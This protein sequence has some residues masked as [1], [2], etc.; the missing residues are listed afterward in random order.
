VRNN[1]NQILYNDV[2]ASPGQAAIAGT[3]LG[4]WVQHVKDAFRIRVDLNAGTTSISFNG[5]DFSTPVAFVDPLATKT[6]KTI[7]ADFKGI[8]SG[9]MG[10][11]D[12]IV[13]R[14]EDNPN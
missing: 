5:G 14:V 7:S 2:P 8:D 10:W 1:V 13:R 6:F 3:V 11:D 9:T 4:N 12:V